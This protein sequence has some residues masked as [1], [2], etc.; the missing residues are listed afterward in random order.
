[1]PPA[2]PRPPASGREDAEEAGLSYVS[3][4]EP[5]ISRRRRGRG[6]SYHDARGRQIRSE[7][8]LQRIRDLAIPPAWTDVWICASE[9]GHIQAT[10]RDA[11]GRKQYR[12]HDDWSDHRDETKFHR[13]IQ[14]AEALPRLRRRVA[15]DLRRRGLPP[16]K[17]LAA[18]VRLLD[19]T[20][21]RVGNDEYARENKAYG[22]TTLR[23]PHAEAVGSEVRLRFSGKGGKRQEASLSD[24]RLAKLVRKLQDLPG[25][26]LFR[27]EEDDDL[28]SV[29]SDQVNAYLRE[30]SGCEMTA[31]DLRTWVATV[32]FVAAL[33]DAEDAETQSDRRSISRSAI[34]EVAEVLGNTATVARNSYIHPD[35]QSCFAEG[36]FDDLFERCQGREVRG[37]RNIEAVTLEMLRQLGTASQAA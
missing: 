10:G 35:L 21:A 37:L 16:E 31:K 23:D 18:V 30:A 15:K 5:G 13:L 17:V 25:Q 32:A 33:A 4:E 14:I 6:F 7:R 34:E 9:R 26:R 24:E 36:A 29:T 3:D 12:Y 11:K 27:Y 2:E 19:R 28:R 22:L 1:M 8:Q 20:G